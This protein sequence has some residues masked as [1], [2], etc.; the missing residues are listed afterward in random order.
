MTRIEL[1]RAHV[2]IVVPG[3]G[4]TEHA[5]YVPDDG[6][7][8]YARLREAGE[9]ASSPA[10]LARITASERRAVP[11]TVAEA[12]TPVEGVPTHVA[13]AREPDTL[14]EALINAGRDVRDYVHATPEAQEKVRQGFSF[15]RSASGSTR[16]KRLK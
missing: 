10:A 7:A 15:L 3:D 16:T 2:L 9:A 6:S 11:Q 1:G 14:V 8:A 13:D 4:A 12:P 5:F